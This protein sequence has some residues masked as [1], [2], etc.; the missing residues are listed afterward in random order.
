MF[1]NWFKTTNATPSQQPTAPRGALAVEPLEGR[2]LMSV[3]AG[4]VRD[5]PQIERFV[6]PGEI[7]MATTVQVAL[8]DGSGQDA[9]FIK[10]VDPR[11]ADV[12]VGLAEVGRDDPF[13]RSVGTPDT[14]EY[15][16][17]PATGAYMWTPA[18]ARD[19]VYIKEVDPRPADVSVAV[20]LTQKV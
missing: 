6:T 5:V 18:D 10:E 15:M 9:V 19:A 14:R 20:A 4:L 11:P 3:T 7:R 13:F 1:G 17:A 2:D 16:W 8:A 12:S